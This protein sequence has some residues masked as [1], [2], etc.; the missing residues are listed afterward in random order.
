MRFAFQ[1]KCLYHRCVI[2]V[3]IANTIVSIHFCNVILSVH[4]IS[5]NSY[6]VETI[7]H[8]NVISNNMKTN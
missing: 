1:L 5:Y 2:V 3:D 7:F 8:S 4:F 6:F